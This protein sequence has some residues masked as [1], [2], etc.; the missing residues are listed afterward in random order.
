M[1]PL[2]REFSQSGVAE[3]VIA[4]GYT[5]RDLEWLKGRGMKPSD[6]QRPPRSGDWHGV[7]PEDITEGQTR[8]IVNLD[9]L[10]YI[11]PVKFGQ[12]PTHL[13]WVGLGLTS[14]VVALL[15]ARPRDTVELPV[16]AVAPA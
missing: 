8:V 2:A 13:Q 4:P 11:D 9:T 3:Y 14:L 15:P 1:K 5:E 6:V 10:E 12:A 7:R 16:P